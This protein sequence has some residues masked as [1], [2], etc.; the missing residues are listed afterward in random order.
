VL[1][2]TSL[3]LFLLLAPARVTHAQEREKIRVALSGFV[4]P[5]QLSPLSMAKARDKTLW[6]LVPG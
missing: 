6:V 1:G 2:S 4:S 5:G 3:I